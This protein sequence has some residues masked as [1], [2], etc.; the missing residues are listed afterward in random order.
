[1]TDV[2]GEKNRKYTIVDYFGY[3]LSP[4]ERMSAIK[5][6][7]FDGV[8][9]LWAD[10]FDE[11]Y[12]E[13]PKYAA[14]AGLFVENAHAP[15]RYSNAIWED[16]LTGQEYIEHLMQCVQECSVYRIPT[17]VVH[18]I[19][20][21]V[22]LPN[23]YNIE[24]GIRRFQELLSQAEKQEINIAIENQGNPEYIDLVFKYIQSNRLCFCFDSGH[25]RYYS[26]EWNLLERY[27]DKLAALH[28]HD[29][30]GTCDAHALPFTGKV[31]WNRIADKLEQIEYQG[32]IALETLNE[33][34]E[35]IKDPIEFLRIALERAKRVGGQNFE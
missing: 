33:G 21:M 1:M 8:I 5:A 3:N 27:G 20:G 22:P 28:L 32:A 18:P 26:P 4:K 31:N 30:D 6:A 7:G 23:Q 35:Q 12:R 25:E 19:N 10:Y 17:L 29:N 13:F 2:F 34:F 11:D 15:Y 9:L 14:E 16:N 24:I